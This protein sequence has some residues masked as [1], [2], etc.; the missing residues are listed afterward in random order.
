MSFLS[1]FIFLDICFFFL[2]FSSMFFSLVFFFGWSVCLSVCLFTCL[3]LSLCLCYFSLSFISSSLPHRGLSGKGPWITC[4][5]QPPS[6]LP[7]APH[8]W[9]TTLRHP[10]PCSAVL[11]CK[12]TSSL[13]VFLWSS[14]WDY[15][16]WPLVLLPCTL[17]FD[18]SVC[19][20]CIQSLYESFPLLSLLLLLLLSSSFVCVIPGV[21]QGVALPPLGTNYFAFHHT[22]LYCDSELILRRLVRLT[23]LG[24]VVLVLVMI[25]TGFSVTSFSSSS[26]SSSLTSSFSSTFSWSF[27]FF[28]DRVLVVCLFLILLAFV[29]DPI[30][31]LLLLFL[32]RNHV[33]A[34]VPAR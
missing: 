26:S 23:S 20:L 22:F 27:C 8:F 31:L 19:D 32:H 21:W 25:I 5:S 4:T 28:L 7:A 30:I 1:L 2:V 10:M 14:L 13:L 9:F 34:V 6:R 15:G 33:A 17:T 12:I 18:F 3:P 29:L 16:T 11:S 24:E